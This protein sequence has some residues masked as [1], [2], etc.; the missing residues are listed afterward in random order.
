[1]YSSGNS[2]NTKIFLSIVCDATV[3]YILWGKDIVVKHF[4]S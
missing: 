4:R 2:M 3:S 1:M